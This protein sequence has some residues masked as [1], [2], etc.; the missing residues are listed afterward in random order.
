MNHTQYT[1][2]VG[3]EP[4]RQSTD[5]VPQPEIHGI[6]T[7]VYSQSNVYSPSPSFEKAQKRLFCGVAPLAFGLIVI[8]ALLVVVAAVGGGVGGSIAVKNAKDASKAQLAELSA[9]LAVFTSAA[10]QG[11]SS[12]ATSAQFAVTNLAWGPVLESP[13]PYT[14]CPQA[15]TTLYTSISGPQTWRIYCQLDMPGN[16]MLLTNTPNLQLC[17]ET[18]ANWNMQK[19]SVKI[20]CK[21]VVFIPNDILGAHERT[22][23]P[24]DCYLKS[25]ASLALLTDRTGRRS[26]YV[27]VMLR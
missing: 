19:D 4:V 21:G 20:S 18:C 10:S 11:A 3:L 7:D 14:G 8:L 13:L 1:K 5:Y 9:S 15:N 27:S 16:D 6:K 17:I 26:E 23:G 25:N 12:T 24:S 2:Q 22:I